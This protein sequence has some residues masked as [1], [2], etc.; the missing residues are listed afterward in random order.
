MNR[1][2]LSGRASPAFPRSRA[3][4]LAPLALAWGLASCLLPAAPA[5]AQSNAS[6]A[7]VRQFPAQALR[8]RLLVVAPPEIR[9]DGKATRLSPGARIRDAQNMLTM[10]TT[11]IG[12]EVVVNYTR[13]SHG[14]VHEV[15]I[16]NDAEIAEKRTSANPERNFLFGSEV[17]TTPRD[18]GKTPYHQLPG[19]GSGTRR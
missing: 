17:D 10:S 11:L 6:A 8:G 13:E 4:R 7:A 5:W 15:W 3:V 14:L 1:C 18:D 19:L 2:A 9:M 16:L 12:R